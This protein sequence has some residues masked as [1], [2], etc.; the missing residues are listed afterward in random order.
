MNGKILAGGLVAVAVLM[1]AGLFYTQLY[2]YYTKV[3]LGPD[4]QMTLVPASGTTPAPVTATAFTGID[5][6]SSP[7]RFRACFTLAPEATATAQPYVKPTP[8]I[9]PFWFS[10]YNAKTLTLDLAAGKAHAY[11]AQHNIFP[12]VDRV[13]AV[14]PDG[15]AFAWQQLDPAVPVDTS[16]EE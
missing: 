3:S 12:G 2:A 15:R 14:Y 13:I 4:L 16:I 5:A 11:L 10:C 1:G 7:L 6:T 8:L 9:A